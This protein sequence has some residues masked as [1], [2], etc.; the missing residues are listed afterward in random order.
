MISTENAKW[1]LS[2]HE[3]YAIAWLKKKGFSGKIVK[4]FNSK[5]IFEITKNGVVDRFELPNTA[6]INMFS[7]MERV[8]KNFEMLCLIKELE[9]EGKL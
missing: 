7:Y 6:S 9:K 4:Q 1:G 3:N 2:M 5:T 8:N